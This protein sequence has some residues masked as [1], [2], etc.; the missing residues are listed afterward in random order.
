MTLA[1]WRRWAF[2]GSTV[3]LALAVVSCAP[4]P[5]PQRAIRLTELATEAEVGWPRL[6]ARRVP[7]EIDGPRGV[8]AMRKER[9]ARVA[10]FPAPR[11]GDSRLSL[12]APTG[13]RY[14]YQ[15]TLPEGAHLETSLGYLP[16]AEG[17]TSKLWYSIFLVADEGDGEVLLDREVVTRFDGDWEPVSLDLSEWGGREITLT[18]QTRTEERAPQVWAAW[19]APEVVAPERPEAG[20]DVV[21][22]SLDTLRADRLGSYGY[23]RPTSPN[24][25][26]LAERSIR[27]E[28]AIAQAPWTRPS[29]DSMFSGLYPSSRDLDGAP[30]LAELL[31][32]RGYR[33]EALTGGGQMDFRLGF[34]RGFDTYRVFDW[35]NDPGEVGRWLDRSTGRQRF[36]FLHTYE[37]HDPYTHTEF[38]T[39]EL[40]PGAPAH[41]D[42]KLHQRIRE[43]LTAEQKRY[44]S[45]L[46]D[47]GIAYTDRQ[48]AQLFDRLEKTGVFDRAIVVITSD[49]GEQFWEHGS[50]RHGMNL[51]DHQLRVPLIVSLPPK[52]VERVGRENVSGRVIEQQVR[53]VDL[54]PTLL[55]L[56]EV[57]PGGRMD[58]R[59]LVPLLAG[60]SL[61]PADA[62][63]ERL[64]VKFKEAKALRSEK[65]KYV[66]SFPKEAGVRRGVTEARELYDLT[67]DPGE[68]DNLAE[69]RPEVVDQLDARLRT[70]LE[71]LADPSELEEDLE[72]LDPDLRDRL[73]ALGY[74]GG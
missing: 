16:P 35:V 36:L 19:A 9:V 23:D 71:L 54:L 59:S 32:D 26:A 11:D 6:G 18:L 39:T 24:L 48:L 25:D 21:L 20:V 4:A 66:F 27:F 68:L 2:A 37:I 17:D 12:M 22:L 63:A 62:F 73:E 57:A 74:I 70:L 28:T 10:M 41:Y 14:D 13:T 44:V 30:V 45:D 67:R 58:G 33:T 61:P 52:L 64:N 53:L 40:E 7:K 72:S 55:E 65:Y 31:H 42:K 29:H 56:L 50:W 15:L 60:E 3:G 43:T 51:Y 49:H 38:A 46:Y 34:A 8:R 47:S 1:I 5:E 69:E